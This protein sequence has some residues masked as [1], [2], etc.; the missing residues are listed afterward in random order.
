MRLSPIPIRHLRVDI[1]FSGLDEVRSC[2][3]Y[4]FSSDVDGVTV[5]AA[6]VLSWE[7]ETLVELGDTSELFTGVSSCCCWFFQFQ[8]QEV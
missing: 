5:L 7:V 4:C 8:I 2:A 3:K 1:F 6:D